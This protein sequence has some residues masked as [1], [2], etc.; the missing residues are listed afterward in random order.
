M[1]R[2]IKN[3]VSNRLLWKAGE[4]FHV[5]DRLI[6]PHLNELLE[7]VKNIII[8]PGYEI[9]VNDQNVAEICLARSIVAIR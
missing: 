9:T 7:S 6:E 3:V 4:L 5:D 8:S 1:D 2:L